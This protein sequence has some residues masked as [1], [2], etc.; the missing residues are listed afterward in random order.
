[1]I[2]KQFMATTYKCNFMISFLVIK[3]YP[4]FYEIDYN[5]KYFNKYIIIKIYK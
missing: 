3:K 2:V 1:M 5:F 4:V